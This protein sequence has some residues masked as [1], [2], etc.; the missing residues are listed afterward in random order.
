MRI[1][2]IIQESKAIRNG[3]EGTVDEALRA[4][5]EAV[6]EKLASVCEDPEQQK[7]IRA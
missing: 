6:Q 1:K 5:C 3:R 4:K 2:E 7:I